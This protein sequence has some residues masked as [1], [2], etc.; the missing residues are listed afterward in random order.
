MGRVDP[1]LKALTEHPYEVSWKPHG[2]S[3]TPK[4][5]SGEQVFIKRV[6]VAAY[7]IGDIVYAKVKGSFYLHLISAIDETKARYQISNN[8]GH[9][10]GWTT[11]DK[12][13]GMC[14]K[15]GEKIL[16]TDEQISKRISIV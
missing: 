5:Y 8:H 3:M 1:I 4:I 13:F 2:N 9:V 7:R 16:I 10:N 6:P 12:L 14:I 15:V 11:S